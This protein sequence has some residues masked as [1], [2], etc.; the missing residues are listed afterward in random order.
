MIV[1]VA[2]D[3]NVKTVLP[4]RTLHGVAVPHPVPIVNT[5]ADVRVVAK[6]I[7]ALAWTDQTS[8]AVHRYKLAPAGLPVLKNASPV[9]H[10][11][12]SAEPV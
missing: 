6:S 4:N 2:L 1:A 12:G 9:E 3:V 7:G 8:V 11:V 5:V 10:A